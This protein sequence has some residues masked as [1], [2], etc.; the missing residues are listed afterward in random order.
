MKDKQLNIRLSIE[1]FNHLQLKS[2]ASNLSV[3]DY[4]RSSILKSK[5]KINDE[6]DI[7][8]LIGSINKIGNNINQISYNLNVARNNDNLG[9]IK[10]NTILDELII[11][12]SILSELLGSVK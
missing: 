12:E 8:K 11:I 4:I 3:S 5:I 6:K 10:Y 1:L 7:S 2:K 9:D